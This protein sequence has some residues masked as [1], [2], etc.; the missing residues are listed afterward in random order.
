ME[1]ELGKERGARLARQL[2]ALEAAATL[3]EFAKLPQVR[4][5]QL[6]GSRSEQISFDL[7]QPY[8]LI[9]E[10]AQNPIPRKA[11]R[12]LDWDRIRALVIVEIT[13]TH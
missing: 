12:G 10:V 1:K 8:R 11:D 9:A 13:D 4:C 3:A 6:K 2:V 5:H 7:T